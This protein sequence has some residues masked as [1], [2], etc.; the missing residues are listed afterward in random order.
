MHP[1]VPAPSRTPGQRLD[2]KYTPVLVPAVMAVA[3]SFVM[4]LIQTIVRLG[5][6]PKLASAWLTRSSSAWLWPSQ[7]PSWSPRPLGDGP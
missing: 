1:T 5:F 4:S 6:V 2:P 7:P 3:M